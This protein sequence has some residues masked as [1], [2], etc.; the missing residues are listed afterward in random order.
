M[1]PRTSVAGTGDATAGVRSAPRTTNEDVRQQNLSTVL[2]LVHTGGALSRSEIGTLTGLNR[3]TVTA[4]A[5][6]L[7]DL[8]LVRET[9]VKPTGRV[10]RP[11]LGVA[12][13][14]D[15]VALSIT[16]DPQAVTVALV[17]LG[18]TVHS[19][20]RHD[21]AAAP[22]P[23][24]FAQ[25]VSSLVD[26]MRADIERHYRL[27]GAGLAVPGLVDGEGRVLLAPSLGW[28]KENVARRLSDALRM[29]VTVGNDA[30][31]GA[32]AETRF[33]VG[34][35]VDN[36][37]YL[38]GSMNG[39]GGGLVFDGHLLRG[40]S[41]FAGEFG[42]TVVNSAGALCACGR[43]GCLQAEVTPAK[44]LE[45]LGR[46]GLD[47]DELDIELGIVHD[48]AVLSEISRQIDLLSEALT[49]FV[50]AF[51]PEMVVLAGYLGVLLATSRERL[52]DAVRLHPVGAEG[53]TVRLERAR[54]RSHLMQI[55]PAELAFEQLLDDPVGRAPGSGR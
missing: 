6:E 31:V 35:G 27:V 48:P 34:R 22:G 8:R 53:R 45:L 16:A 13:D 10:G 24:R 20:V 29:P 43:R 4:L 46:R 1:S 33:G 30:G 11:S 32:R 44:V 38:S 47:E 40:T 37:L 7:L 19:R 36:V 12:A 50:N 17:G 25:V 52:S 18:G 55:A 23:R 3:S 5:Q 21:L 2:R 42:H 28:R 9:A 15:V 26:G 14:D 49:N 41:G 54:L 51:A 39:I